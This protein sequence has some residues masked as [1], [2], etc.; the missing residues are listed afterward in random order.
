MKFWMMWETAGYSKATKAGLDEKKIRE[1]GWKP[2]YDVNTG[3][4]RTIRILR[5]I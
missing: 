1:L 4:E 3:M 5:E 2:R